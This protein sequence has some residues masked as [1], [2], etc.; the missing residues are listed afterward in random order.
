M[1]DFGVIVVGG[2][3]VGLA[4]A[5]RLSGRTDLLL[6]ERHAGWGQETS[7]RN[8]EVIH[9]GFYYPEGSLKAQLCVR[10]NAL[11]YERCARRR[12]V[13]QRLTKIVTATR[14]EELP[15]LEKLL[16]RGRANGVE[17]Q[18]LTAA[19]VQALEPNVRSVGALFSPSTG[20]V[21]AHDLM[22]DYARQAEMGGAI[23]RARCE[24]IAI[25]REGGEYY[26]TVR[27]GRLEETVS[28]EHF[29]NAA[30]LSSDTIAAM[31]G[32]DIDAAGYRLHYC[33]GSYFALAPSK[34]SLVS[35]LVYPVPGN[36]SLGVHAVL[37]V[38]GRVRFGPD[39]EYLRDRE[40][41]YAVDENLRA[42]FGE[43]ARR[44]LPA[45]ADEDLTPDISGVRAKLQARGEPVRDFVIQEES[46]RGLPGLINLV[47]I[48]SP[49]LTS[50][51][52]IAEHVESLIAV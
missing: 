48:D 6:L 24:V 49:G 45:V 38:A 36:E 39:V 47:G 43:A 11:L 44:Y 2:G 7:S 51:P 4:I 5:A 35:R 40:I 22:D 17:L 46:A 34:W 52:A 13:H 29:V 23:L 30:G 20:V 42:A 50:S 8:S 19:E 18:M 37:D 15:A 9:A 21:N 33:K 28:T 26:V 25:V 1:A 41:D 10:G 14:P 31:A 3:A 32:I 16:A 27:S 12:I